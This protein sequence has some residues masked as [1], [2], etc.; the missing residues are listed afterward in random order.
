MYRR[1]FVA[2]LSAAT[3]AAV[4]SITPGVRAQADWPTRPINVIVTFPAGGGSDVTTRT[5]GEQMQRLLGQP[6]VV[7]IRT[8]AGGNVGAGALSQ[9]RPDGYT[10][11]MTTP[12]PVSI[13]QTI[14]G[15]LTYDPDGLMPISFVAHSP[16]ILVANPSL[17]LRNVADLIKLAKERPGELTFASPGI[18]TSQHL[19]GELLKKAA[20]IDIVHVAY[21]GGAYGTSDMLG[22]RIDLAFVATSGLG[23][24]REGKLVALGV[25]SEKP[26]SALPDIPTIASQGVPGYA[27]SGWFGLVAPKGTPPEII[28]KINQAVTAVLNEKA[29]VDRLQGL[30]LD[31]DP[32]TPEQFAA[33]IQAER[34]KWSDLLVGLPEVRIR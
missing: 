28:T 12:G 30:G 1:Q 20:G 17:G 2:G 5:V 3:T 22:G 24:V 7:D 34:K 18:G 27:A 6:F 9:S 31:I 21:S 11:M 16:N 15:K 23:L 32:G 26:S 14:Y 10:L 13:N 19:A 29:T 8:G 4:F 25:T 33:F